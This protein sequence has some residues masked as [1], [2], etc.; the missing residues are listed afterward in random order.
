MAWLATPLTFVIISVLSYFLAS[1]PEAKGRYSVVDALNCR[2][3][4]NAV[5]S[6]VVLL[7]VVMVY[8]IEVMSFPPLLVIFTGT[9]ID[10]PFRTYDIP[11]SDGV[12]LLSEILALAR[13]YL[14]I[15]DKNRQR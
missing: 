6:S 13:K 15:I 2:L 1:S 10:S 7:P 3:S 12:A 14:Y 9:L 11:K 5:V 4:T 8:D